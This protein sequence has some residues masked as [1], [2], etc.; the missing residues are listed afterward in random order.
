MININE[1]PTVKKVGS[2]RN[3]EVIADNSVLLNYEELMKI[4]IAAGAD[5]VGFVS[6]DHPSMSDER[7]DIIQVLPGT[8]T[9]ISFVSKMN[10]EPVRSPAR[11]IAN[12]EF[13][14]TTDKAAAIGKDIIAEL[15]KKKIRAVNPSPGFPMEMDRFSET[16]K[17]WLVS[18]KPIAQAA[19]LGRMG[20]HRNL[21]HPKF[22]NFIILGTILIDAEVDRYDSELEYNPCLEC[23]LCVA[24]CPVGAIGADGHF[25]FTACYTHNYREFMGGFTDWVE[26]VVDSKNRKVYRSKVTASETASLWQSLSY[27]ANYKAA[28]CMAVCPAGEDVISPFLNYKQQFIEQTVKPLQ[29]KIENV[30]VVKDS[31]A[32]EYVKKRFPNKIVREVSN[33]LRPSTIGGFLNNLKHVFQRHQSEGLNA[34]YHF[35][36]F[37][38]EPADATVTIRNKNIHLE[39][40]LAG[41]ADIHIRADSEIWLKFIAKEKNILWALLSRKI[42]I[43]GSPRLLMVFGKCFP[44]G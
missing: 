11:S 14:Q 18:H 33:S 27:G 10:C 2:L 38:R 9:L 8:K 41:K 44:A 3:R 24:A 20:I 32:S 7:A 28:Y 39:S 43:K 37:G 4:C 25:D 1:H 12:L 23:K 22:G 6:V 15:A 13:H 21:I 42:K 35:S 31:D 40:G 30:Y 17:T 29:N 16:G 26:T 19:G 34:V 5:D 36:F